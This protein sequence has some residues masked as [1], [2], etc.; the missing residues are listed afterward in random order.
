MGLTT[1]NER[2][3]EVRKQLG[4]SQMD[5]AE[6]VG[7]SQRSVSWGE[8]PGNNVPDSTVKTLCIVFRVN[9]TWLRTG[10]GE[11]FLQP[12]TFSLDQYLKEKGCT[13]LELEIVKA[14]F[15]LDRDTRQKV[16]DHFYSRIEA[17][18]ERLAADAAP[19]PP[20]EAPGVV[21]SETET[22]TAAAPPLELKS[23]ADMTDAEIDQLAEQMR[24]EMRREKEAVAKSPVLPGSG[25]ISS[26]PPIGGSGGGAAGSATG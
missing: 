7:I 13:P 4:L 22:T 20:E 10:E 3:R 11:M 12:D 8:Q 18:K 24:Q 21:I 2:I 1:L 25:T 15:E 6:K 26:R 5:F 14:Y 19:P 16:F 9:E 23:P 17:A